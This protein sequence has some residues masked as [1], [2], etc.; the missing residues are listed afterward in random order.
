MHLR[1]HVES[2]VDDWAALCAMYRLSKQKHA[3]HFI[4]CKRLSLVPRASRG[5]WGQKES[6][7]W[8]WHATS[9]LLGVVRI[10]NHVQKKLAKAD[11]L[12]EAHILFFRKKKR[13]RRT[14]G[15]FWKDF[16]LHAWTAVHHWV[17]HLVTAGLQKTALNFFVKKVETAVVFLQHCLYFD[18]LQ[19]ERIHK[20][21]ISLPLQSSGGV[22]TQDFINI[23]RE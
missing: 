8:L 18:I 2:A 20:P 11:L 4:D 15:F 6:I 5:P 1:W 9:T 19:A 13:K 10:F 7:S 22:Q 17:V 12:S 14:F 21:Q 23:A 16:W 3:M